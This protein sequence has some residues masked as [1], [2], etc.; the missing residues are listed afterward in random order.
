VLC[1]FRGRALLLF[2][3][4]TNPE[5]VEIEVGAGDAVVVPA[6]VA[7]R[8][9]EDRSGG[10]EGFCMVGAYPKGCMWDMCYGNEGEEGNVEK[11]KGVK[12]FGKDPLYGDDG[13]VLWENEKL[14]K[15]GRSEL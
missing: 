8:L 5:K 4:E 7:H 1:V 9:L 2:G 13:P 14:E 10:G 3:G 6:G 12:W 11:A 15:R